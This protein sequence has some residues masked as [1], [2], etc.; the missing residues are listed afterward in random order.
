MG[1]IKIRFFVAKT[2]DDWF[3]FGLLFSI[4][5]QLFDDCHGERS[6]AISP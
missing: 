6:A 3:K 2:P 4:T 1:K 5:S